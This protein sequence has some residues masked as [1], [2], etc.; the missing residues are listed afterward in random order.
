MNVSEPGETP[1][2]NDYSPGDLLS[3]VGNKSSPPSRLYHA[4]LVISETL[5]PNHYSHIREMSLSY[6]AF[7]QNL[8]PPHKM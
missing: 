7:I 8:P 2:S 5:L 6:V 4:L 3:P 1:V